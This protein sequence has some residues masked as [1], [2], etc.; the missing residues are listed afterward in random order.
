MSQKFQRLSLLLNKSLSV[1]G[2][3]KLAYILVLLLL[4]IYYFV[5]GYDN[6]IK[7]SKKN[8]QIIEKNEIY[9]FSKEIDNILSSRKTRTR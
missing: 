8:D 4:S 6:Y 5:D 1:S 3:T 7:F 9:N 2:F